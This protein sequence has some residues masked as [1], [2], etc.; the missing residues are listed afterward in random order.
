MKYWRSLLAAGLIALFSWALIRFAAG[1]STLIDMVYPY[2]TRTLQTTLT[3]W[4]SGADFV[5]WQVLLT[6]LIAAAVVTGILMLL[7][8][9][10][11][12]QWLGWVL[13]VAAVI[14]LLNTGVY[15]LNAYADSVAGD[16]RMEVTEFN[17]EELE[18]AAVYFRDQANDHAIMAGRDA[19]GQPDFGSFEEMTLQ[20]GNGFKTLVYEESYSVFAG[21]T[22]PVKQ[23][24]WAGLYN[25]KTGV[26]CGLTGEAAVNPNVPTAAMPF[27]I[28]KE[29]AKRMCI[30]AEDDAVFSA[31]LAA[32]A[33]TEPDFRYSGYLMAYRSCYLALLSINS[34]ASVAAAQR[35]EAGVSDPVAQDLKAINKFVGDEVAAPNRI[36]GLVEEQSRPTACDLLVSWYI[37]EFILPTQVEQDSRFDPYDENSVD[38]SGIVNG[39]NPV[40][41]STPTTPSVPATTAPADTTPATTAP[42][43]NA[44]AQNGQ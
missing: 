32:R 27:A 10:N 33:N 25:G 21:S 30:L 14:F 12:F 44:N 31:V 15:G 3:S 4:T 40:V 39:P 13:T 37:Q 5:L 1:H 20:A 35:L 11:V 2:V 6:V 41:P 38:L 18:A 36:S 9:W 22:L 17:L 7:L 19:D 29:M 26:T 42:Q 28:C 43:E 16:L 23:L 34:N 8:R 24:S